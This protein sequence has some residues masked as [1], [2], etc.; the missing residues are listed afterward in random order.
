[1]QL[2][3][4]SCR[5]RYDNRFHTGS[6]SD[7]DIN[8]GLLAGELSKYEVMMF[9]SS[10]QCQLFVCFL[11]SLSF[12]LLSFHVSFIS[13][14]WLSRTRSVWMLDWTNINDKQK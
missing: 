14:V 11:S 13:S 3:D 5:G 8:S 4:N 12:R 9:R 6:K 2:D 1:M 7:S 10:F